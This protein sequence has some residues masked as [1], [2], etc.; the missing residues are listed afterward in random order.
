MMASTVYAQEKLEE[1]QVTGTRISRTTMDT[2]TPVTTITA[3]ELKNMN[4]GNLID[5]MVEMPQYYSNQVPNQENGGQNSGGANINLRGAGS[6]RTLVLI[7]GRRVVSTNRFGNVDINSIP[8]DLLKTVETVTGGASASYGT[9]A[10]AG[11]VNF[12]LDNKFE[13]FKTHAQTGINE[14]GDGRNWELGAAFGKQLTDKLHVIGSASMAQ[15]EGIADYDSL[16][17]RDYYKNWSRIT[18]PD[19]NGP[20]DLVRPYVYPTNYTNTGIIVEPTVPALNRLVFNPDGSVTPLNVNGL[21]AVNS[22]CQCIASPTPTHGVNNDEALTNSYTRYNGFAYGDYQLNDHNTL[23]G[24]VMYSRNFTSNRWQSVPLLSIWGGRI[25][26][27]NPYLTNDVRNLIVANKPANAQYVSYG[28]FAP[29]T[30]DS[31]LGESRENTVNHMGTATLG[32]KGDFTLGF[33][34]N[35]NYN[36]YVQ[37]GENIQDFIETNGVRVD[38]LFLA[39]DAVTGPQGTPICRVNLPQFTVPIAQGGNGGLFKDCVPINLIG[40]VSNVSKAAADY[41]MDRNGKDARQW[42]YQRS[43]EFVINGDLH[44]GIGAGPIGAAVGASWRSE[45]LSQKTL[46]PADEYP[47]QVDGTLLSAQGLMPAGVRGLL[48]QGTTTYPGYNGI[49]GLR[50][51]PSGFTGD[52][53]SSSVLFSSLR[54]ISGGFTVKEG[55][56]ELNIPLLKDKTLVKYA[57]LDLSARYADYSGSGGIWAWKAG[58]N[59]T[60]NDQVR[61]RAT[62]SRD[63]RAASLRER[64]DQTRGG[65]TVTNPWQNN[66]VVSAAS[67]SGGNPNVAPEQADTTTVGLVY[68]PNWLDG[69]SMS[70]DHYYI[71]ISDAIAQLTAQTIV[72]NCRLGDLTMCQYVIS[73]TTGVTDPLSNTPRSIDRVDALFIN[74]ANQRIEGTDAEATYKTDIKLIGGAPET[75]TA[76]LLYAHL[77]QN[78]IQNP[79]AIRIERAG[80]IGTYGFARDKLNLSLTYNYDTWTTFLQARYI[81]SGLLD[82]TYLESATALPATLKP[83]NSQLLTCGTNICTIDNNHVPSI[84]YIDMKVSK[85]L[86]Q[87]K[88]TELYANINNLTNRDPIPTPTAIGRAGTNGSFNSSMYDVLG[89][90]YTIGVNYSF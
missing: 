82:E 36:T 9:D 7:D 4:P 62:Q 78:S 63:V 10:V 77:D 11:V 75:L 17:R 40:G 57:E 74:L 33:M 31:A 69:L 67:F 39:M 32:A 68:R 55:F 72:N 61:I 66:I 83:A 18:D 14:L 37:F 52:S 30:P 84:T 27:E 8:Q 70:V 1:I 88:R 58:L 24:Q 51:V 42:T 80:Q 65:I 41:V 13:G 45:A 79:G 90:R 15:Q 35:W 85:L 46:N 3:D 23:F 47:A 43:W 20:T 26:A 16:R 53:N 81:G 49:A 64:Y 87:D 44:Q 34:K 6:N 73:G 48:P 56:G 76:R 19:P 89:R 21:G 2:P 59:W 38:R 60:I 25:Y 71:D 22:G 29:N 54:E 5:A 12:L 50:Y 86:G 28:I